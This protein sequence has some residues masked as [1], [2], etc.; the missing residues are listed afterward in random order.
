[1]FI[2]ILSITGGLNDVKRVDYFNSY[3]TAIHTAINR[4]GCNV[5]GYIA[6]SL[7]DSF[8]WKAG[9]TE[10]FGLYHVDFKHPNR[11]RT[12]KLSAFVYSQIAKTKQIDK[13]YRPP[14]VFT[15]FLMESSSSSN[16]KISHICILILGVKLIY[17]LLW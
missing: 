2:L 10:K 13:N 1:M 12:P 17:K 11:T 6:W 3:L 7:M 5:K 15:N 4:D 16:H 14:K 8:E 9:F